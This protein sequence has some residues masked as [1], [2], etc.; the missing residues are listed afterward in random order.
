M[1]AHFHGTVL[2]GHIRKALGEIKMKTK[3][4]VVFLLGM[5]VLTAS[6]LL[7]YRISERNS[8]LRIIRANWQTDLPYGCRQ[9]YEIDS[10]KSF[11]GDGERYHVF[12][13][14]E[15][16]EQPVLEDGS[17]LSGA[18]KERVIEILDSLGAD[19]DWY[20]YF[21]K[22]TGKKIYRK[23]DGSVMYLLYEGGERKLYVVEYFL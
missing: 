17:L 14:D 13:Y 8:Y 12:L 5:L 6:V 22:V 9:L 1:Q 21:E 2:L 11:H 16:K 7:A 19:K 4:K 20:P 3:G 15:R 10:G 18:S 23:Q